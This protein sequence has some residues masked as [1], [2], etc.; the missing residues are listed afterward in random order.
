MDRAAIIVCGIVA[1]E[2]GIRIVACFDLRGF[3]SRGRSGALVV[4]GGQRTSEEAFVGRL[5]VEFATL[6]RFG[7]IE[8]TFAKAPSF[9]GRKIIAN[10]IT[11]ASRKVGG[12]KDAAVVVFV[13][14]TILA[15]RG[16][17]SRTDLSQAK[18]GLGFVGSAALSVET[19]ESAPTIA[20]YL[21]QKPEMGGRIAS[22]DQTAKQRDTQHQQDRGG[23]GE[24]NARRSR[25]HNTTSHRRILMNQINTPYTTKK[26]I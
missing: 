20:V 3:A 2:L 19:L 6:H 10:S 18:G 4:C 24:A 5:W 14:E 26:A 8:I 11:P 16:F 15:F 12:L 23:S 21:A 13:E 17:R 25:K 22:K 9:G 7:A 1:I